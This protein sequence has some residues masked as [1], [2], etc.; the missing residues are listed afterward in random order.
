MP[1]PHT[2][3]K[4]AKRMQS[5]RANFQQGEAALARRKFI[6]YFDE[7]GYERVNAIGQTSLTTPAL[8]SSQR[9]VP[10]SACI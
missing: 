8:P 7:A 4:P 9:P 2:C 10:L 6:G 1:G 3:T 5:Y